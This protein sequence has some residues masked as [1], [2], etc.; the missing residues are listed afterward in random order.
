MDRWTAFCVLKYYQLINIPNAYTEHKIFSN[1]SSQTGFQDGK[2]SIITTN[3]PTMM[4]SAF[5]IASKFEEIFINLQQ[6]LHS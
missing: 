1:F 5:R 2:I 6:P 4:D 3:N